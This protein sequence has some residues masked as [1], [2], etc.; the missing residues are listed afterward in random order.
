MRREHMIMI[1]NLNR[2]AKYQAK[3][4]DSN[5]QDEFNC[6]FFHQSSAMSISSINMS[7]S[8]EGDVFGTNITHLTSEAQSPPDSLRT[9]KEVGMAVMIGVTGAGNGL[10][11]LSFVVDANLRTQSNY[12]LLNLAICDFGIGTFSTP[13]F[14]KNYIMNG[15]WILGRHACKM[16]LVIDYII[17]QCSINT[18]I[19]ISFDRFLAVTK[20]V[21]YREQQHKLKSAV[22]KMAATWVLAFLFHGPLIISWEYIAG[23]SNIPEGECNPE[24]H[25]SHYL[26]LWS[27]IILFFT[28]FVVILYLN[29]TI[30]INI[31]TRTRAKQK[32]LDVP[33]RENNAQN[34]TTSI[35]TIPD[36]ENNEANSSSLSGPGC[37]STNGTEG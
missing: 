6:R 20:P 10:V 37:T 36:L 22:L 5:K 26:R 18:I 3:A 8:F 28:P 9:L 25:Y 31:K 23:Y 7:T 29:V 14:M 17:N 32:D 16:W 11:I 13:L 30:Y 19:L 12:Y 24:Y 1:W 27:S 15:K 34:V 33:P 35:F 2:V 21:V 4:V